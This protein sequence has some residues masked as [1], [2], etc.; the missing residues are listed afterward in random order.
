MEH[1]VRSKK[2]CSKKGCNKKGCSK[3]GHIGKGNTEVIETEEYVNDTNLESECV[4]FSLTPQSI[5]H[6]KGVIDLC[7]NNG[8][9]LIICTPM[10]D[11]MPTTPLCQIPAVKTLFQ[12]ACEDYGLLGIWV[13]HYTERTKLCLEQLGLLCQVVYGRVIESHGTN[14]TADFDV[15][16]FV[17]LL[18]NSCSKFKHLY[19]VN[20]GLT[21]DLLKTIVQK[22]LHPT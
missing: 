2:I 15:N 22:L 12:Q 18:I 10:G 11:K 5:S 8:N 20:P 7:V 1:Q 13:Y 14:Y 3:K 19:G 16:K 17:K 9:K 4:V 6:L 21:N